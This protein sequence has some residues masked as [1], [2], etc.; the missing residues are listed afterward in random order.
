MSGGVCCLAAGGGSLSFALAGYALQGKTR[1]PWWCQSAR[2]QVGW[3]SSLELGLVLAVTPCV[4]DSETQGMAVVR[5]SSPPRRLRHVT[6][7][8]GPARLSG[9]S[10]AP[11]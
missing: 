11:A 3:L 1:M 8:L 4:P 10:Y 5:R 2:G 6:T 9:G 7:G